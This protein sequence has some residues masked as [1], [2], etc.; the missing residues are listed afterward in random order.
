MIADLTPENVYAEL[1]RSIG[2]SPTREKDQLGR[3]MAIAYVMGYVIDWPV[4]K[5]AVAKA[6]CV[7]PQTIYHSRLRLCLPNHMRMVVFYINHLQSLG[8][9]LRPIENEQ[10]RDE[11]DRTRPVRVDAHAVKLKTY[12]HGAR[13][14]RA[15][16]LQYISRRHARQ[17]IVR[18]IMESL[19]FSFTETE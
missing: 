13:A 7:V 8:V 15:H 17:D 9:Q 4:T 1:C 16:I 12:E 18:D 10:L 14:E 3:R 19:P 2:F 5:K 11:L 6:M